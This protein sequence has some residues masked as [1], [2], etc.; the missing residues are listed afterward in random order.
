MWLAEEPLPTCEQRLLSQACAASLVVGMLLECMHVLWAPMKS[1]SVLS[2]QL[3]RA[4]FNEGFNTL[5]DIC[6]LRVKPPPPSAHMCNLGGAAHEETAAI[7][8]F[9]VQ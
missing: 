8:L 7:L 5:P 1:N 3:M 4:I 6:I 2:I 9:F